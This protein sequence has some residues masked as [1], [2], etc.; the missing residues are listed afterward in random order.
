MSEEGKDPF[1]WK[2]YWRAFLGEVGYEL[3][4]EKVNIKRRHLSRGINL[5]KDLRNRTQQDV[6]ILELVKSGEM[7]WIK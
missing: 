2:E 5:N 6:L 1:R 4:F 3:G 7:L